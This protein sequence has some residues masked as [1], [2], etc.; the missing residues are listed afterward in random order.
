MAIIKEDNGLI[1]G[2]GSAITET[3]QKSGTTSTLEDT[4]I[5]KDKTLSIC[6]A[7]TDGTYTDYWKVESGVATWVLGSL[8]NGSP[9]FAVDTSGDTIKTG[10]RFGGSTQNYYIAITYFS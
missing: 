5:S 9:L 3:M 10:Q 8:Y 4:G 7:T 2:G 6:V 1:S